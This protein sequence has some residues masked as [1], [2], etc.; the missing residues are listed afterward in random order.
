MS[1][2][3]ERVEMLR[4]LWNEGLSASQIA[5]ELANGIT[6]N[7]VI[8]KVHRLGLSGRA[9]APSAIARPR[10]PKPVRAA[11]SLRPQIPITRGNLAFAIAPRMVEAP[12]PRIVAEV[13]VPMTEPVTIMELRESTCRWPL[14]DPASPEFRYCGGDSPIG[15]G[16]YCRYHSRIAYQPT[17]NR[18]RRN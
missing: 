3:D 11:A 8:G 9:K 1:W 13:V 16:P 12:R 5:G 2:T 17:Q 6:R 14:G 4:K 10:T 18:N 7:A 15:E